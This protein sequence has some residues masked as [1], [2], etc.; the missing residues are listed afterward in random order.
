[1]QIGKTVFS[2]GDFYDY[3]R[4]AKVR[5]GALTRILHA[6]KDSIFL[7]ERAAEERGSDLASWRLDL[8]YSFNKATNLASDSEKRVDARQHQ[9]GYLW[10]LFVFDSVVFAQ[11][12]LFDRDNSAQAPVLELARYHLNNQGTASMVENPRSLY[13]VFSKYFELVWDRSAPKILTLD[14][15][16]G[17]DASLSVVALAKRRGRFVFAV[18]NRYLANR[19]EVLFHFPGGKHAHAED[20]IGALRR[21]VLEETGCEISVQDYERATRYFVHASESSPLRIEDAVRP[22]LVYRRSRHTTASES[23]GTTWIVG[24]SVEFL[25]SRAPTPLGELAAV[26]ELT[27]EALKQAYDGSLTV[28]GLNKMRDGSVLRKREGLTIES[29]RV[30]T[31]AGVAQIVAASMYGGESDWQ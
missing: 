16:L 5:V 24:Y 2:G 4:D 31:P 27:P 7:T 15:L 1:M 17:E 14:D 11:P 21:E 9:E 8:Q 10:R 18:P 30:L 13:G 20:P 12:Y 29:D 22:R 19:D 28:G 25:T 3:L 6:D 26:I 23:E